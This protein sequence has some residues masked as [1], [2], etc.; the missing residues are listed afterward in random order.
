MK[1]SLLLLVSFLFVLCFSNIS[2][3]TRFEI[4]SGGSLFFGGFG[5]GSYD[6]NAISRSFDL[7]AGEKSG[8]LDFFRVNVTSPL[9]G[10]LGTVDAAIQ[11]TAPADE[12]LTD[13]GDYL[14]LSVQ[15]TGW[16]SWLSLTVGRISWGAPVSV[17]YG[18]G[19]LLELDL[20]DFESV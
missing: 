15:G 6:V 8:P 18:N 3:A 12:Y 2:N 16:L 19:G 9:A 4:G 20:F 11:M 13:Q 10:G 14:G 1:K 7:G 17:A 5:G